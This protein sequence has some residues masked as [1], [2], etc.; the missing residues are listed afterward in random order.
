MNTGDQYGGPM[1]M[2][3]GKLYQNLLFSSTFFKQARD[4][5]AKIFVQNLVRSSD[6]CYRKYHLRSQHSAV[7][8]SLRR[9]FC[10]RGGTRI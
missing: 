2:A 3:N 10:L 4:N 9:H 7:L 6:F 5:F 8:A 1:V